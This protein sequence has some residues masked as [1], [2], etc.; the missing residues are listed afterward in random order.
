MGW[1]GWAEITDD[2][3]DAALESLAERFIR[4]AMEHAPSKQKSNAQRVR[5]LHE[6]GLQLQGASSHGVNNCLIDALLL[7]LLNVGLVPGTGSLSQQQRRHLR[8]ACRYFLYAEHGTPARIYLDAHR[9]ATR[10]LDFFLRKKWPQNVAVR[11]WLYCRFDHLDTGLEDNAL[12]WVDFPPVAGAAAIRHVVHIY[13]QMDANQR[14]YHFDALLD[15]QLS[16]QQSRSAGSDVDNKDARAPIKSTHWHDVPEASDD[17]QPAM[18]VQTTEEFPS[19]HHHGFADLTS[20]WL[21]IASL[22]LA[23]GSK[24]PPRSYATGIKFPWMDFACVW[25][26]HLRSWKAK[27]LQRFP[28]RAAWKFWRQPGGMAQP[29]GSCGVPCVERMSRRYATSDDRKSRDL[30]S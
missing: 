9:D 22:Q 1:L 12:R 8:A 18:P 26:A 27:S 2:A 10:I 24:L 11:V 25:T 17:L 14:G 16:V 4:L 19:R 28:C 13:N 30:H 15:R 29:S 3:S 6:Q 23:D 21:A 5:E 20:K 7:G